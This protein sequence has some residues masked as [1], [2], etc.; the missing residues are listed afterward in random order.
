MFHFVIREKPGYYDKRKKETASRSASTRLT[1]CAAVLRTAVTRGVAKLGRKTLLAL[2]DHITQ[3]LPGPDGNYAHPLVQDYVKALTEALAHPAHVELLARKGG[4]AWESCVDFLL[5]L[6]ATVL[7]DQ[8][9]EELVPRGSPTPSARPTAR[10]SSSIQVQRRHGQVDG[11]PLR[12]ALQG[13]HFLVTSVNAPLARRYQDISGL[14][15]KVLRMQHFSMGSIQTLSFAIINE[16]FSFS[17]T[18]DLTYSLD[19]T[20]AMVPHMSYWW[21]ADKVSQ[22]ELIRSLRNEISRTLLLAQPY[23][24]NLVIHSDLQFRIQVE[25]LGDMLWL[26]YSRRSEAFRLQL[27]DIAFGSPLNLPGH[28]LSLRYF[29]LRSHNE[30]AE[31]PWV[32]LKNLAYIEALLVKN[33]VAAV[34]D[35][36]M[37]LEDEPRKRRKLHSQPSRLGSKLMSGGVSTQR[38]ALQLLPFIMTRSTLH[39]EALEYLEHVAPLVGDKDPITASWAMVA[40]GR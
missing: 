19:I 23:L 21:R 4:V 28:S 14:A 15:L 11:G 17:Q 18:D 30:P 9:P 24:E 3:T 8:P 39:Q 29:G 33:R 25:D 26:E 35:G 37:R 5:T 20:Q 6:S 2:V 22:D 13:L 7:P 16:T 27:S 1:K 34:D 32:I 36:D 10:A 12:D 40:C 31:G 38:T